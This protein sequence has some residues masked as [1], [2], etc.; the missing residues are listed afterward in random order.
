[1]TK[2]FAS[3]ESFFAI[4]AP[5]LPLATITQISADHDEM[6]QQ[7]Q[8]WL[9]MPGVEEALY[10]ASPALIDSLNQWRAKP[11]TKQAKKTEQSL[12]KY[13][14]RMSSRPT[15]FGLFSGIGLGKVTDKCNI[16]CK[17][18]LQDQRKTRLDM[19]YLSA[20][21][22][23]VATLALRDK[24]LRYV[25]NSSHYFVAKQCRYIEPY[26]SNNS[27]QYRLSA[28]DTDEYFLTALSL[29]KQHLSFISLVEQ[30]LL[31]YPEAAKS[32]VESYIEQLISESV[33]V[34]NLPM[35]LT[36]DS[37]DNSLVNTLK[38]IGKA[39]Y[40]DQLATGLWKLQ[41][42]DKQAPIA[43][44][45]YRAISHSLKND[46]IKPDEGKLF[47][48]DCI[49]QFDSCQLSQQEID[50]LGRYLEFLHKNNQNIY[51]PFSDFIQKFNQRFEGQFVPL[52]LLLDEESGIGFSN[53]TGYE[54]PLIAGINVVRT[55]NKSRTQAT[56]TLLDIEIERAYSTPGASRSSVL[57]ISSTKMKKQLKAEVKDSKLPASFAA[58]VSCYYDETGDIIFK[59]N[60]CYGP[61]AA[62]LLGRFCHL[63]D[64]LKT[65]VQA[66]LG[67]EESYNPEVIFAE[68]AHVPEGRPGNVI[69]RPHLRD[70]EISFMADSSVEPSKQIG[71]SD[72]YVWVENNEVKLWS[73]K[74]DKQVIPRLSCAHNY[75]NRSLSAYRF[76]ST[77]QNQST[78]LPTFSK[79]VS[80]D[81]AAFTPRIMIDNLILAEKSWKIPR[82]ELEKLYQKEQINSKQWQTLQQQ[83]HLDNWVLFSVNDNVLQLDLRNPAMLDIL[84][85]E[86]RGIK[87]IH[88]K[89]VLSQ[90]L[91]PVVS[92]KNGQH[93]NSEIIIPFFNPEATKHTCL[94]ENPGKNIAA[95][96]IIRRFAPGSEWLSLKIYSGN[97]TVENLLSERL[98]PLI[99]QHKEL[100]NK[101]FFIRYGDPDWHIRLRFQGS[102]AK[103]YGQLL[104]ILN[105]VFEPLLAAN[106][107]HR[108]EV[109][110]YEREVERYGGPQA[111]E[112]VETL[113]MADSQL[114]A[115]TM[116]SIDEFGEDMRWR[117]AVL[118]CNWLFGM[119]GYNDKDTLNLLTR[120]RAGFGAEFNESAVMR[121]QLGKRFKEK[122]A[123]LEA[124]MAQLAHL[125][126]TNVAT[127][128]LSAS[129][130]ELHRLLQQWRITVA[131]IITALK[132]LNAD[133]KLNCSFDTLINSLLHMHNNRLFKAYGREQE[134]VVHDF[135]RR[136]YFSKIQKEKQH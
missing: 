19:F 110:T 7:L 132:A 92:D 80:M 61:S 135:S 56:K 47:Q 100:F 99:E 83:Y 38:A 16:I 12:L 41:E 1:M 50:K 13:L 81:S 96:N 75:S 32:D 2:P 114:I 136:F 68:I 87:L 59:F 112:L 84:L 123:L 29:A 26:Q 77:L 35:P 106:Q 4:R 23:K 127:A 66:H 74:H 88:L 27:Q 65:K 97:T 5:R 78:S 24:T 43:V 130:L 119:F 85:S 94:H 105:S 30:F 113:F 121:K 129:Q 124:D 53:E 69:A 131:P 51:S 117:I 126:A 120:L 54:S 31:T 25:P 90:T 101:W 86:S 15:P 21:K 111:M 62:N 8:A 93:Y 44:E 58:M 103:L 20:L 98:L 49:R 108:I 18:Y 72:L 102:P 11:D 57:N 10:L 125:S 39:E 89:E 40:S 46:L 48:T 109:S 22:T 104:P 3:N 79:P 128:E 33:L 9:A 107:L 95:Q 115:T 73:I 118:S 34:A 134:L 76:L 37:P 14:I 28:I 36:G 70:Y 6:R 67:Q 60:G 122:Q 63:D 17:D 64:N 55:N 45:K 52:N 82:E 91:S 42:F 133:G 116:Q 71:L